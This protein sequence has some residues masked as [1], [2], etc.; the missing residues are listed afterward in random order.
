MGDKTIKFPIS[1]SQRRKNSLGPL[2][3][4]CQVSGRR[5]QFSQNSTILQGG[6]FISIDVMTQSLGDDEP[7]K[8]ICGLIVTREDLELALKNIKPTE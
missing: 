5:L 2:C 6:E 7:A 4:E 1:F 8:K 3:V